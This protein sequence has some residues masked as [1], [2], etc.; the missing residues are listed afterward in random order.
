LICRTHEVDDDGDAAVEAAEGDEVECL[1]DSEP[2]NKATSLRE[3]I[4]PDIECDR[5]LDALFDLIRKYGRIDPREFQHELRPKHRQ[6]PRKY[7]ATPS[8]A[9]QRA[10]SADGPISDDEASCVNLAV[11]AMLDLVRRPRYRRLFG[12]PRMYEV[13]LLVHHKEARIRRHTLNAFWWRLRDQ[14]LPSHFS[15]V[16]PLAATV[17]SKKVRDLYRA[18]LAKYFQRMRLQSQMRSGSA[19]LTPLQISKLPE[20][21]LF[22][23]VHLLANHPDFDQKEAQREWKRNGSA[24]KK[25][26]K[27]HPKELRGRRTTAT[28]TATAT[29][30]VTATATGPQQMEQDDLDRGDKEEEEGGADGADRR[31]AN[32][33]PPQ[34][35]EEYFGAVFDFY[36]DALL[37]GSGVSDQYPLI[38]RVIVKIDDCYDVYRPLSK[39]HRFLARIA[40]SRFTPRYKNKKFGEFPG[41]VAVPKVIFKLKE[42]RSSHSGGGGAAGHSGY[43][44]AERASPRRGNARKSRK[45]K[46]AR[47]RRD[48]RRREREDLRLRAADSSLLATTASDDATTTAS[49]RKRDGRVSAAKR[50]RPDDK[51]EDAP[52]AD[53]DE[54]EHSEHPSDD[55]V[56]HDIDAFN[57]CAVGS[58]LD[59]EAVDRGDRSVGDKG[60]R[61]AGGDRG[62]SKRNKVM[63]SGS[64]ADAD[65]ERN[66][67][68]APEPKRKSRRT[69]NLGRK[70]S[71]TEMDA[72]EREK[73]RSDKMENDEVDDAEGGGA[74]G[75]ALEPP[76]KKSRRKRSR[77]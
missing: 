11:S 76:K 64:G 4:S 59:D 17:P 50:K 30:T 45:S 18:G 23:L 51:K 22:Y 36:F 53:G 67:V 61:T 63:S 2:F 75:E 47:T 54:N 31:S 37:S 73:G 19:A 41:T 66:T 27:V 42:R 7:G 39:A 35:V 44:S 25:K 43:D 16:F 68:I 6:T 33:Q 21:V 74:D 14:K 24:F 32:T 48:G 29:A 40:L 57:L 62:A 9:A 71:R 46:S 5:I 52:R 8:A 58:D 60:G 13:G 12:L 56:V 3:P 26:G 49:N 69:N 70:R 28:A 34:S 55:E 38:H 1:E 65:D 15:C 72:A 20:Y 77:R 10:H